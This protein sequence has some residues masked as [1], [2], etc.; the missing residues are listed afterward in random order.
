[1]DTKG[2]PRG[3]TLA[4]RLSV[5][6]LACAL[7]ATSFSQ[8]AWEKSFPHAL[9]VAAAT[10]KPIFVD[11]YAEWCG[12]CKMLEQDVFT[13]PRVKS[14]M[15]RVVCLRLDVDQNQDD[16][17]KYDVSSIPRLLLLGPDGRSVLWDTVGYRDADTFVGEFSEALHLK[18]PIATLAPIV[19]DPPSVAAVRAAITSGSLAK[20]QTTHQ[21]TVHEG[22][23]LLVLKLGVY[24]ESDFQPTAGLLHSAGRAA[25]PALV[26][27]MADKTLAVRVG[28]YKVAQSILS[29]DELQ[30]LTFDPWASA[31]MRNAQMRSV[32]SALRVGA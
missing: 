32:R 1:V 5:V 12:P 17:K 27:G 28:A 30:R 24:K 18:A 22:L 11:F 2:N 19:N 23:R 29:K 9:S 14:L 3:P 16:A 25:L 20:L 10:H 6:T 8:I 13:D 21:S 26:K 7:A 4:R 15:S 31:S